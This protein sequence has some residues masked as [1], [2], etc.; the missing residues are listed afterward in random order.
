MDFSGW[1]VLPFSI[2][3]TL[4]YLMYVHCLLPLILLSGL[5]DHE[6]KKAFRMNRSGFEELKTKV[7]PYLRQTKSQKLQARRSSGSS[8]TVT[9][10]LVATLKV[11]DITCL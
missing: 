10:R 4:K 7:E 6:F 3:R 9:A 11:D 5:E 8:I 2:R 1:K